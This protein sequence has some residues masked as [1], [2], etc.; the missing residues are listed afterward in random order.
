MVVG[1][2]DTPPGYDSTTSGTVWWCDVHQVWVSMGE[3][4]QFWCDGHQLERDQWPGGHCN[5]GNS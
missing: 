1:P 4:G 2:G 3:D 5:D